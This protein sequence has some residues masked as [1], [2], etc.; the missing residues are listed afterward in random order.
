MDNILKH[1]NKVRKWG[2][3]IEEIDSIQND[4]QKEEKKSICNDDKVIDIRVIL[5]A[6]NK[7]V[8]ASIT[9]FQGN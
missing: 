3:N 4:R 7:W 6:A 2:N 5:C 8:P 9:F 1:E